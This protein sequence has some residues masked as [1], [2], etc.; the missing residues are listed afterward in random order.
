M[1]WFFSI[2]DEW[3]DGGHIIMNRAT[4]GTMRAL[5]IGTPRAYGAFPDFGGGD[6]PSFMGTPVHTNGNWLLAGSGDEN[7]V[8][9]YVHPD[10]VGWVENGELAIKVDP[11]GDAANG[12]VRYFPRCRFEVEVLQALGNVTYTDHA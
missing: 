9:T 11:Y 3:A 10:A 6:Y 12:R 8:L 4:M 1:A 7:L 5:L 2:L